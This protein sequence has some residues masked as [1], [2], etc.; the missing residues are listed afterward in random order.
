MELQ[1]WKDFRDYVVQLHHLDRS[2]GKAQV[3][4]APIVTYVNTTK[5]LNLSDFTF[6]NYKSED[7]YTFLSGLFKRL[8]K[9]K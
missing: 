6:L 7:N 8:I 4:Q 9:F 3:K 1:S 2:F 5:V